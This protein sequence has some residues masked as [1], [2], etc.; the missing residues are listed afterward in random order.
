VQRILQNLLAEGVAIR[1]LAGI[2]E[3][4]SDYTG[5]TKNPDELSE[6]ARRALARK[7]S[8]RIKARKAA[9]RPSRWT[10]AWNSRS[11]RGVRQTP[12]EISLTMEP[13][14]APA[15]RGYFVAAPATASQ[16]G[17][18]AGVLCAPQIRLLSGAFLKPPFPT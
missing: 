11:P 8:S 14:L 18:A 12:T 3:K 13:K 17:P 16:R 9:C 15:R 4:V 1:N 7:S 5:T 6:C 2:L 10:R